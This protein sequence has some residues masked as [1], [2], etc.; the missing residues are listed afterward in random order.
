MNINATQ[1]GRDAYGIPSVGH[2][3]KVSDRICRAGAREKPGDFVRILVAVV[4][5]IA[6]TPAFLALGL[7]LGVF[8]DSTAA[9]ECP[10]QAPCTINDVCTDQLVRICASGSNRGKRCVTSAD[11]GGAACLDAW[12]EYFIDA[13]ADMTCGQVGRFGGAGADGVH[14]ADFDG[15]GD[16]DIVTGW[17]ETGITYIYRN[18]CNPVNP[19]NPTNCSNPGAVRRE[20]MVPYS[21]NPMD[22]RGGAGTNFIEDAAFADFDLDGRPDA[23]VTAN[24]GQNKEV[25]IH[26]LTDIGTWLGRSLPG[27]SHLY[28]QVRAADINGDGCADVV[29]GNKVQDQICIDPLANNPCQLC[30]QLGITC[31]AIGGLWW[32]ECPK[33]DGVCQP[34]GPDFAGP[35]P[36]IAVN[37]WKKR[38]IDQGFDW[39]MSIEL[40]D[41]DG[42]GDND[43]LYS[44]RFEV[45]WFENRTSVEQGENLAG[46]GTPI[47]IDTVDW[48]IDRGDGTRFSSGEPFR[49]LAY[50][51]VDGDGGKDIVV[52][53]TFS[54]GTC[55]ESECTYCSTSNDCPPGQSCIDSGSA[56][57]H[58]FAGYYYRRTDSGGRLWTRWPIFVEGGLPYGIDVEGDAVSK[59]VAIGDVTGDGHNDIVF[60]VR[61]AGHALY[62]LS[63]NPNASQNCA[64]CATAEWQARPIAP[65]RSGSKYDNVMLADIDLDGRLDVVTSEE[66]Y[67]ADANPGDSSG[68]GVVWYRNLGFCGNGVVE[69]SEECDNGTVNGHPSQCCTSDCQFRTGEVCRASTS[70]CD[71]EEVCSDDSGQCPADENK[72]VG[73]PCPNSGCDAFPY[74]CNAEGLCQIVPQGIPCDEN[75]NCAT[76]LCLLNF[77]AASC[78]DDGNPC[79]TDVC[80][81]GLCQHP[82]K[83][84]GVLCGDDGNDCTINQCDG[85]GTC[86]TVFLGTQ[87]NCGVLPTVPCDALNFC[88]GAGHCV[89]NVSPA[90]QVCRPSQGVCDVAEVCDGQ[91][92]GCLPDLFVPVGAPCGEPPERSC[93]ADQSTCFGYCEEKQCNAS[94]DCVSVAIDQGEICF[95]DGNECTI[96][97]CFS[98][99]CSRVDLGGSCTDDGLECTVDF[100]NGPNCQ[101]AVIE[102]DTCDGGDED[103]CT[104]GVCAADG[105]CENTIDVGAVC[106][107]SEGPCDAA[108]TCNELGEC[109]DNVMPAG[110]LCRAGDFF[111]CDAQE[112]CE[113][114]SKECPPDESVPEGTLCLSDG[115]SCTVH[116][117]DANG[118]CAV[119]FAPEGQPCPDDG[120]RCTTDTCDGAGSCAHVPRP[121]GGLCLGS[122]GCEACQNG[123]C[124]T[125]PAGSSCALTVIG[126]D[127]TACTDPDTCDE[128]GKCLPNHALDGTPCEP[129]G[130]ACTADVCADGVCTYPP[131]GQPSVPAGLCSLELSATGGGLQLAVGAGTY[132][133]VQDFLRFDNGSGEQLYAAGGIAGVLADPAMFVARWDGAEWVKVGQLLGPLGFGAALATH[134]NGQ[135]PLLYA[136]V[137]AFNFVGITRLENGVWSA[138]IG[139]P[140]DVVYAMISYD[141]GTGAALYAGGRFTSIDNVPANGIAKW[142]GTEWSALGSGV[143]DGPFGDPPAV[144]ALTVYDL[145]SG[146]VLVVGGDFA[147]AGGSP[148]Q[149]IAQWNGSS[150]G[151][152]APA[153]PIEFGSVHAFATHDDGN[154]TTLFIGGDFSLGDSADNFI[155]DAARLGPNGWEQIEGLNGTVKSLEVFDDGLGAK[156]FAAGFFIIIGANGPCCFAQ[157]DGQQ[158]KAPGPCVNDGL[159]AL[160]AF[161]DGAGPGL[162]LGGEFTDIDGTDYVARWSCTGDNDCNDNLIP[163][164]DEPDCDGNGLADECDIS[165]GAVDC[166][167]NGVPDV[168]EL[169]Q[170]DRNDNGV[171]DDCDIFHKGDWNADCAV[172]VL[173]TAGLETCLSGPVDS[174]GAIC[175]FVFDIDQD[176]DADLRDWALFLELIG[177]PPPGCP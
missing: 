97:Q 69:G 173:D 24:E 138:G 75:T 55:S 83:A 65:C 136:A 58:R 62:S 96:H 60:A 116:E 156:L 64:P 104:I 106:R 38:R 146:P 91:N 168:C 7:L 30:D 130:V 161:D 89:Q 48:I 5:Q 174:A 70:V 115:N 2:F 118:T 63:F 3:A 127:D 27:Q 141:D 169:P 59:G 129:D 154:G 80:N 53:A 54:R 148:A 29:A 134:D 32:W 49:F 68:L 122:N 107:S 158:W 4:R 103:P 22:V 33:V 14:L 61:G 152:V 67:Q 94:R 9:S 131:L 121:D 110:F 143:Q 102:G 46:W 34:F 87:T 147:T 11:C 84:P 71:A 126:E 150:W 160:A 140:N 8:N 45:G 31:D 109:V 35:S 111:A 132:P 77:C 21:S 92:I 6:A 164:N 135:G 99:F 47:R 1:L 39:I 16:L 133:G 123:T 151:S 72:P 44:D 74:Q 76:G 93:N 137:D 144:L 66:N 105:S 28:M 177:V 149:G 176:D 23:V 37:Q 51:D 40:V 56:N 157:W 18:P 17:E 100:C 175:R 114:L 90:G 162:F 128:S 78:P 117:C 145:G 36:E 113:G 41:M 95:D 108:D 165:N 112:T 12:H 120:N 81:G 43:V 139:T 82:P 119:G 171:L 170:Q 42:D 159:N 79:T 167:P 10:A 13:G 153:T 172:D 52:T 19:N 88:D 101:H 98:T 125:L 15:D 20:W 85:A 50:D 86:Q 163:D 73:S 26:A 142:N 124:V 155:F 57:A 166:Q 25:N